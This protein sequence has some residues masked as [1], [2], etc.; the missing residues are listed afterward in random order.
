MP[1]LRTANAPG[2]ADVFL[3]ALRDTGRNLK[4]YY[5]TRPLELAERFGLMLPKKPVQVM[6]ELGVI[7]EEEAAERF[8]KLEPGLRDLVSDVC[9]LQ[10][11]DAVAVANRGGGKSFGVSFIEF[12]LW[13][14]HE[15]DALNLGGSEL[16]ADQVYQYLLSYLGDDPYWMSLVRGEAMRERTFSTAGAWVRVL[17]ASQKSVRSPHAGGGPKK[18]RGGI[19]VID[20]EAEAEED[21]VEAALATVNTARPSVNVRCSTFHN[22]EGSFQ[23]VVDN[24]VEM[25]YKLYRWDIFD[26][27]EQCNCVG[28]CQSE[29]QCF[30]EDHFE[31]YTDPESGE[32]TRRLV[33]RAYCGGRAMY[34]RGWI[35]I[36]EIL[37]MWRRMKRNHSRWEVEAMGSRPSTAGHVIKD[38]NKFAENIVNVPA[39]SL[40]IP[41]YPVEIDVDWGTGA[42]GVEV[43]QEQAGGKHVLLVADEIKDNNETQ[44]I[45]AILTHA[46]TYRRELTEVAAD[47]GGGGNYLNP[48]LR[49]DHRLPVRDVNF[50]EVKET[51]VA[52]WNILNEAG[53]IVIPAEFEDFTHQVR[54]WKRKNGR[55]NKGDDHLCDT[56]VCHFAKMIDRLGLKKVR[57]PPR[58]FNT[59]GEGKGSAPKLPN[60]P[61]FRGRGRPRVPVVRSFRMN[62]ESKAR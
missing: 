53:L 5:K 28:G 23:K 39:E 3:R 46:H 42:A 48:K 43:W 1:Q 20:E 33:H 52:A 32:T 21:I 40:Y 11:T 34:A 25:G 15:Y 16:Q 9:S 47:I 31:M 37:K 36:V 10:V 57:I 45:G 38:L 24:H 17:T 12:V 44:I 59:S 51:A 41:G 35:P 19:L 56:A 26:V 4:D 29:E 7:T 62:R 60:Q 14:I 18:R 50:G 8:G 61:L 13:L 6:L 54:G 58:S 22:L 30:R 27:A 2:G 49:D 55:I